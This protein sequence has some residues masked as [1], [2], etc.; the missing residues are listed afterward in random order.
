MMEGG[1][2]IPADNQRARQTEARGRTQQNFEETH[3]ELHS[4]VSTFSHMAAIE[5]GMVPSAQVLEGLV[6]L[7]LQTPEEN[8]QVITEPML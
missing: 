2:L 6:A 8:R 3:R 1:S 4:L 5:V 7:Y